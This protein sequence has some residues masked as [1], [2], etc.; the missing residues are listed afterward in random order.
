MAAERE[1]PPSPKGV[2]EKRDGM[3]GSGTFMRNIGETGDGM[4]VLGSRAGNSSLSG[5]RRTSP[6]THRR[7]SFVM[8][9][10]SGSWGWESMRT[11]TFRTPQ[12]REIFIFK[13]QI[14]FQICESP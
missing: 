2:T 1:F 14:L 10:A 13:P 9:K 5:G 12:M 4:G 7:P 3:G 8:G 11:G 6:T